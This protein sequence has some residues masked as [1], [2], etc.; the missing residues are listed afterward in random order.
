MLI[1]VYQLM[2]LEILLTNHQM[3]NNLEIHLEEVHL[4]EIHLED[5]H[6]IHL[7]DHLDGKHLTH[8]CLYHHGINN[9]LYNLY[10]N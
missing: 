7:L 10:Q 2:Y 9:F 8:V 5:H 1:Q 4:K 6:L 3:E